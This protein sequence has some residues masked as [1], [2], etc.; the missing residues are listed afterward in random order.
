L[1]MAEGIRLL[2]FRTATTDAGGIRTWSLMTTH[3]V[4]ESFEY[5]KHG[6][7]C[8]GFEKRTVWLK[9]GRNVRIVLQQSCP[10]GRIDGASIRFRIP[11]PHFICSSQL[12]FLSLP[13]SMTWALHMPGPHILNISI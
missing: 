5:L 13:S 6:W 11:L 10:W 7:R 1:A 12:D 3:I 8:S 4:T 9:K 2:L